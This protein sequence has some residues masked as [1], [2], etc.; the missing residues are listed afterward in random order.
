MTDALPP[1]YVSAR[2][3]LAP[4]L[5]EV[6]FD[7]ADP[8]TCTPVP[9]VELQLTGAVQ[10]RDALRV[11]TGRLRTWRFARPVDV[12]L[13]LT[14]W[15]GRRSELA[16]SIVGRH[17]RVRAFPEAAQAVL[18]RIA[19]ELELRGLLAVHPSHGNGVREQERNASAW[20]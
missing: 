15:S 17:R 14:A 7:A 6:V 12:E 1:S 16:L 10:R 13:E 5:A 8:R 19:E 3:S 20:L 2:L 9:G 11:R 4:R 18:A